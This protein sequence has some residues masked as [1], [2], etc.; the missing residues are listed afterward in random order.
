MK[1]YYIYILTNKSNHVLYTGV[2]N[3]LLRR[4]NQHKFKTIDG[5]TKK[6]NVT[7]LVYFELFSYVKDAIAAEKR[8]KGWTRIKKIKLI[9][10][11][12]PSWK[13]LFPE[14]EEVS[15]TYGIGRDSSLRSE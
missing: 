2:T 12:N 15:I 9:E 8:I 4:I 10:S 5:F 7:K 3:S 1:H 11:M 13:D 6:Y 14:I